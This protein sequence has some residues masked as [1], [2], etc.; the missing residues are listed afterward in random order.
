VFADAEMFASTIRNL[1]SNAVKFTPP[2][3]NITILAKKVPRNFIDISIRDTGIGMSNK[4]ISD[5]FR[6]TV[7][8]AADTR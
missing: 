1:I 3:G 6:F 4:L 2:F 8:S 5:L 7:P